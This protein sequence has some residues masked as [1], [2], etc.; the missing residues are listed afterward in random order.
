MDSNTKDQVVHA[1]LD[2]VDRLRAEVN[3]LETAKQS[4]AFRSDVKYSP[5]TPAGIVTGTVAPGWEG[6][7]EAFAM[8]FAEGLEQGSQL[9]VYHEGKLCVDLCGVH[10]DTQMGHGTY[11]HNALQCVWSSGKNAEVITMA[12]LTDRGLLSYDDPIAKH[13]PEFAQAGKEKITVADLMRHSAGMAWFVKPGTEG[14]ESEEYLLLSLE[15][16]QKRDPMHDLMA[17]CPAQKVED[18]NY[19]Y[20][21]ITRGFVVDGILKRVDPK[22]RTI[23]QFFKDEVLTPLGLNQG[24]H[25]TMT[26]AEASSM[27]VAKMHQYPPMYSVHMEF[28]PAAMGMGNTQIAVLLKALGDPTK[29]GVKA[30]NGVDWMVDPATGAMGPGVCNTANH[31]NTE[32]TS[33][34]TWASARGLN[35]IFELFVTGGTVDGVR[36]LSEDAVKAALDKQILC[37]D[38]NINWASSWSQVTCKMH[39]QA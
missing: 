16:V 37:R 3:N 31:W 19:T 36:I 12:I 13:W 33:A 22:G 29:A 24:Y 25:I 28:G 9:C 32:I 8:N 1:L 26:E 5:F 14:T 34:G 7:R 15:D 21:A 20:H 35:K 23:G 38:H 6:V 30:M 2:E 4:T 18:D 11:D 27:N 17:K 39:F 10:P